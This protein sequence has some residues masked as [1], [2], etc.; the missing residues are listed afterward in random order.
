MKMPLAG[1]TCRAGG[2]AKKISSEKDTRP[3]E[4][5]NVSKAGPL[6]NLEDPDALITAWNHR[7]KPVGFGFYGKGWQPRLGYLGTYDDKW[8]LERSPELPGDF[9]PLFYNG[10][11][12]D[13]QMPGYLEGGEPV[14]L[15]NLSPEGQIAFNL[16]RDAP[17]C[18]IKTYAD[19]TFDP[20]HCI[21]TD[22]SMQ[23]DTLCIISE[24]RS[25]YMVW[26]GRYALGEAD[27]LAVNAVMVEAGRSH[28]TE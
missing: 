1:W 7:P 13:L 21:A 11:H 16:P 8:R 27:V 2:I 12:P 26:R 17:V 24:K 6:P 10:A 15:V 28:K 19:N 25:F 22:V 20:E 5:K 4:K 18:R 23:C 14:E 3:S 9:D